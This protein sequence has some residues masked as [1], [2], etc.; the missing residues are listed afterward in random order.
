MAS[1]YATVAA[2]GVYRPPYAIASVSLPGGRTD[3]NWQPAPGRQVIP[4]PVAY[5]VTRVL[6]EVID[7]GT[8][9]KAK[10]GRPAAGKT[11]TTTSLADAWFDG[12]TPTLA[13]AVWVGYPQARVPMD[14]VHGIEVF[15]GTFP[16][17]I[18]RAYMLSALRNQ[19]PRGFTQPAGTVPWLPW[20]GRFQYAHDYASA[21]PVGACRKLLRKSRTTTA[22]AT[23]T[24]STRP[25]PPTTTP[26][27]LPPVTTPSPRTTTTAPPPPT[28]APFTTTTE[29]TTE[30]TTTT[31]PTTTTT[32][33]G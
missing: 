4:K 24:I 5:Q 30:P 15:G 14:H 25:Q 32:A 17:Q 26:Q 6:Q 33:G 28:S 27:T 11:G 31:A 9:T 18:W 19:P 3:R 1:A 8:G 13:A 16:A 7:H 20:C 22:T 2:Q 12:Y 21:R 10:L 23:T 29:P